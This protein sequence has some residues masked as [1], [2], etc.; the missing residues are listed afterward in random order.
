MSY[1]LTTAQDIV[2]ILGKLG[3]PL[4]C[5]SVAVI[6]AHR[7]GI[8]FELKNIG[9]TMKNL[10]TATHESYQRYLISNLSDPSYAAAY[11]ET[12][13]EESAPEPELLHLALS[14]V[15]EALSS[16]HLPQQTIAHQQKLNDLLAQ[17]GDQAIHALANWLNEIGLKLTVTVDNSDKNGANQVNGSSYDINSSPT[18]PLSER[19]KQ[20]Q[21][22][23]ASEPALTPADKTEALEQV[24]ILS[25][26]RQNPQDSALRKPSVTAIKIIRGTIATLPD[27]ARLVEA[28]GKL[29]PAIVSLLGL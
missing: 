5:Y 6:K 13:L 18:D 17:P 4:S 21:E 28:C 29:L 19:L 23:I 3:Q 27:T 26:A 14:N 10:E 7:H 22:A 20:L 9:Q 12:H 15:A 1:A 25:Q 8:L 11:L 24:G 16:T 2:S